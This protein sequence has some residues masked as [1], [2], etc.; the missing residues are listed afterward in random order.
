M[1][2]ID[3]TPSAA[4]WYDTEWRVQ[5]SMVND[6]VWVPI[7][8]DSDNSCFLH[9]GTL[10]QAKAYLAREWHGGPAG[11]E[12]VRWRKVNADSYAMEAKSG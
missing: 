10:R 12:P 4:D 2:A 6:A 7:T 3:P 11:D 8:V 9:A 1:A 5:R